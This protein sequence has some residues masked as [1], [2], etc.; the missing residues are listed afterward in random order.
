VKNENRSVPPFLTNH[1]IPEGGSCL[2]LCRLLEVTCDQY[3]WWNIA[4]TG[5]SL[6]SSMLKTNLLN[7][8]HWN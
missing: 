6:L 2:P 8:K 4:H 7:T 1:R 3:P 5:G